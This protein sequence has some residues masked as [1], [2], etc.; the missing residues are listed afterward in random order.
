M[1]SHS[2]AGKRLDVWSLVTLLVLGLYAVFLI[3]P[4][5]NLLIQAVVNK[6]TGKFTLA[7]FIKFFSKPYYFNTLLNSFKVTFSVTVL[8]VMLGT[9]LAY[10]FTRYHI[11]GN[12]S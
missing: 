11:R 1:S 10:I 7:Y 6:E 4:L 9:P 12:H 2:R 8:T 5:F 3:Y